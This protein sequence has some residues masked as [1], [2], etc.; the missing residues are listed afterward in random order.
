MKAGPSRDD[1]KAAVEAVRKY[2][3]KKKAAKALGIARSTLYERL[4]L[5]TGEPDIVESRP[6]PEP[7]SLPPGNIEG[8]LWEI[9]SLPDNTF[10][11][12]AF[13]D[14]HAGSKYCRWDVRQDL[15]KRAEDFKAQ[16]ILDTGNWIDG[17]K[18]SINKFDVE[19]TG[20]DAQC[21]LLAQKYP[22][23]KIP[24]YAVTGDDHEGWFIK[25][26]GLDA[27]WYCER[28]MREAGHPWTNLGFMESDIVLRNANSG[29]S[30]ILRVMHPGGGSA[31][32][33]SYRPQKIVESFEGA[34]KPAV[35]FLGH[36]HKMECGNVRNVWYIQTGCSCDQT[37]FMRKKSI[38]A[39]VG[40]VLVELE[41]DPKTGAIISMKPDMIRYF[42]R[43]Y[44]FR[45]GRANERWSGSGPIKQVPRAANIPE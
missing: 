23:T 11:F 17:Y 16:A 39:H 40:G 18:T 13:G 45:E 31:Y 29:K 44:Y 32:A 14:L 36:Y 35:L 3:T 20:M 8:P 15:T 33:L 7:F 41:Q 26:E 21:R 34:E 10:R 5:A 22:H 30:S 1:V 2:G 24:T 27:G 42:N 6:S 4:E 38:E 9:K 25:S 19:A 12:G 37:P 43:G 28:K